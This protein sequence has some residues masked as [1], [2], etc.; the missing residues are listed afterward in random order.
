MFIRKPTPPKEQCRKENKLKTE[1]INLAEGNPSAIFQDLSYICTAP[2]III[3][4]RPQVIDPHT[5]NDYKGS[6]TP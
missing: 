1:K 3:S 2:Q 6:R 5:G 4:P